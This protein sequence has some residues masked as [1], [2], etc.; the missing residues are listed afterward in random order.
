[1]LRAKKTRHFLDGQSKVLIQL[2]VMV[3]EWIY[4]CFQTVFHASGS[5][6]TAFF[7][8][9]ILLL[10]SVLLLQMLQFSLYCPYL[11]THQRWNDR[12]TQTRSLNFL[13]LTLDKF[14]RTDFAMQ[15]KC[16]AN[17]IFII[18]TSFTW[19]YFVDHFAL[20]LAGENI[21]A[22]DELNSTAVRNFK[23]S[24]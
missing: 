1:M 13:K 20:W 24:L 5:P 3:L 16:H 18:H 14:N 21:E 15:C 11:V 17:L 12:D 23:N 10:S 9:W 4:Q 19:K 22:N 2:G 7:I 6:C 8:L